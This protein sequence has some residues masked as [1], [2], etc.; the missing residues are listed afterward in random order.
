MA[1]D[2]QLRQTFN[3]LSDVIGI[4]V[5]LEGARRRNQ[6][7]VEKDEE[8]KKSQTRRFQRRNVL[9]ITGLGFGVRSP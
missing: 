7:S 2:G 9:R 3:E 1:L 8:P 6:R 5:D 4:Q